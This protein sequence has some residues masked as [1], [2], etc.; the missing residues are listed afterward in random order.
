[1]ATRQDY[2]IAVDVCRF[3]NIVNDMLD[4]CSYIA[5][6]IDPNTGDVTNLTVEQIKESIADHVSPI[7]DIYYPK[8]IAYIDGL[9]LTRIQEALV[10]WGINA[11][12]LRA[13]IVVM[14]NEAIWVD[15]NIS[16]VTTFAQLITGAN[17]IDANVPKLPLF[18]RFWAL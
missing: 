2:Q 6:N 3:A 14:R 1:M 16:G 9:T 11:T 12:E 5:R 7:T 17:H 10:N 8:L 18:R 13:D 4:C 15:T